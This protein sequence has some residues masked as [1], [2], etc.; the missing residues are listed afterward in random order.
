LSLS[1]V[2]LA[3]QQ[4][5]A[6]VRT[7]LHAPKHRRKCRE[8]LLF[9]MNHR[10]SR[11]YFVCSSAAPDTYPWALARSA[12]VNVILVF[13]LPGEELAQFATGGLDGVLFGLLPELV[14]LLGAVVLVFDE[15]T[16]KRARLDV[17]EHGLH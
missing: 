1:G 6:Q 15:A 13:L 4:G 9:L 12:T 17:G 8:H 11:Q 3:N 5:S 14:E 7:R 2:S 10:C 16:C